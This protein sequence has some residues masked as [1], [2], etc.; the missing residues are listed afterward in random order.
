MA[1]SGTRAADEGQRRP[2]LSD[3][4]DRKLKLQ[5]MEGIDGIVSPDAIVA[6]NTSAIPIPEL[7]GP[8]RA[9]GRVVGIHFFVPVRV[10]SLVEIVVALD[11]AEETVS[12]AKAFAEQIGKYPIET[13]D[14]RASS[15]TCCRSYT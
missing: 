11:T 5:V 7:A 14:R 9:P 13:K 15:S 6:S 2:G 3:P 10:M 4:E 12:R 1:T 8:V